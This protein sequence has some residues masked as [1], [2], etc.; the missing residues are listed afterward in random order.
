MIR[1]IK[2]EQCCAD[3]LQI[4]QQLHWLSII[5][6]FLLLLLNAVEIILHDVNDVS[7]IPMESVFFFRFLSREQSHFFVHSMEA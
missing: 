7:R 3:L 6:E 1:Y 4:E 2:T 5:L